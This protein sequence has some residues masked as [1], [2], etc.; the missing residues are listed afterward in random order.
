VSGYHKYTPVRITLP[1]ILG[2]VFMIKTGE[3]YAG[4]N[5]TLLAVIC[6]LGLITAAAFLSSIYRYRWVQ[7]LLGF[8]ALFL[9][10]ASMVAA[11]DQSK[12]QQAED[13]LMFNGG[14]IL[15]RIDNSPA[16]KSRIYSCNATALAGID[17]TGSSMPFNTRIMIYFKE[18]TMCQSLGL[19]DLIIFRGNPDT[20]PAPSNPGMFSFSKYLEN[21]KIYHQVFLGQDDWKRVGQV[22]VNTI[23]LIA[24]RCRNAF[25]ETFRKFNIVGQ[26][27]ALVSALLLGDSEY[28]DAEIRQEFSYA[29]ATHVLS[30]SGLHVGI[31][32]IAA[33]KLLFILKR[34][35]KTRKLHTILTI[36]FIWAYALLTG[37]STSV[38]RAALMFSLVAAG[39]MFRRSSEN[40]NIL[41]VAAFLQLWLNPLEI[42]QVGFQLSYLAVLGIFAFYQP[43]NELVQS[44]NRIISWVWPII[45]VSLA[46]QLATSSLSVYYF[47][48][49]PVYFLLTN[50]IVVPLSGIIIY[51]AMMLIFAGACG[52][53]L[54]WLGYPLK[55]SLQ[56]MRESVAMIQSWPGAVYQ[57]IVLSQFQVLLTF[58]III[59]L[60][61]FF[62]LEK[63]RWIFIATGSLIIMLVS[64]SQRLYNVLKNNEMIVYY[65]PGHFAMDF[66][67][68]Q[69]TFFICDSLLV[70]DDRKIKFQVQPCRI[71]EGVREVEQFKYEDLYEIDD[72]EFHVTFPFVF[73]NGKSLV[74]IDENWKELYSPGT[75]RCDIGIISGNPKLDLK[76]LTSMLGLKKV[77]IGSS[78]PSWKSDRMISDFA[79]LGIPCHSVRQDGAFVMKW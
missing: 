13:F 56:L 25:L 40:Y 44:N 15:C 47:N 37:M 21:R 29:G 28:L 69:K 35:R 59:S 8:S 2:I 62:V 27:F 46:A 72:N 11:I 3:A 7:G 12:H 66:I 78:V 43:V 10:G 32:Y 26:D 75:V 41:A 73:F 55:W 65:V 53:N 63:R 4:I 52:L 54:L 50:L 79:K 31:V 60:F 67:S 71:S 19:G 58:I 1:F 42:T 14:N 57:P 9:V 61:A 38:T 45:A 17:S 24:E 5:F 48:M 74:L 22:K 76:A 70:N 77:V 33:D 20:I 49:F 23:L 6:F 64:S 51:L 36:L 68:R 16:A 34:N 30:V 18:D 39:K